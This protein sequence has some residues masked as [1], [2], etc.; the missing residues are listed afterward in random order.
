MIFDDM[1]MIIG[2]C[3]AFGLGVMSAALLLVLTCLLVSC[4]VKYGFKPRKEKDDE[5]S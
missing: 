4:I 3:I 5:F 1:I 2:Y